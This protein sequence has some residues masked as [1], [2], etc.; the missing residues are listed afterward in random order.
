MKRNA[1]KYL[2]GCVVGIWFITGFQACED[3]VNNWGTDLSHDRLFKSL[4]FRTL[5]IRSTSVDMVYGKIVEANRYVFEFCEAAEF[6][7]NA[8]AKTVEILADTLT[9]YSSSGTLARI[10]YLTTF[11]NL[12]GSTNYSVRMKGV[13]RNGRTSNYV[14]ATFKTAQ[15][16]LFTL[17]R[18]SYDWAE[19]EWPAGSEVSN[20][21]V[22]EEGVGS[23]LTDTQ[24]TAAEI[25]AGTKRVDGLKLGTRYRAEISLNGRVRG[26]F[27]FK[28]AGMAGSQA[29]E[30]AS[31]EDLVQVLTDMVSAG[32]P[33]I[34]VGFSPGETYDIGKLKIPAGVNS[35][36]FSAPASS[37]RPVLNIQQVTLSSAMD[38]VAFEN[39][40]IAGD[41]GQNFLDASFAIEEI[42]FTA[43]YLARMRGIIYLRNNA[44]KVNSM[45]IDNC[46]IYDIAGYGVFNIAGAN[47]TL[48]DVLLKNTTLI[49]MQ[50]LLDMRTKAHSFVV[51]NCTFYNKEANISCF[52][53]FDNNAGL[54]SEFRTENLILS[55]SNKEVSGLQATYGNY[56]GLVLNFGGSYMTG[57]MFAKVGTRKFTEI[58]EYKGTA[59]D[60][61]V[62]P[63]G[64]DGSRDFSIK[65]G[66]GFSGL[67]VAGDSR[68]FK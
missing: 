63:D 1:I 64:V 53:R 7:E 24:L 54:P 23:V 47:V 35:L 13:D 51:S 14:E 55:G 67:N 33:N 50:Q 31:G 61:F 43:C 17:I 15:E 52:L 26:V 36:V 41:T 39:V 57:E 12:N 60:L 27:A 45:V 46:M 2:L 68:W 34:T 66:A 59:Y 62:D 25:A 10:E 11:E 5:T 48:G 42:S 22:I 3:G 56:T 30:L 21:D 4:T 49:E 44:M 9:E 8:I 37:T 58:T 18:V 65:P 40:N 6:D 20:L 28:T 38:L 16:Q 32:Y 19:F 29:Y